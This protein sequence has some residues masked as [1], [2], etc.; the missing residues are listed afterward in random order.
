M[1]RDPRHPRYNVLFLPPRLLT[2]TVHLLLPGVPLRYF[3]RPLTKEIFPFP[4]AR[5]TTVAGRFPAPSVLVNVVVT[6]LTLP[7]L[8]R[9]I[10][11]K[12]NVP[13]PLPTGHGEYIRLIGLL[14]RS[15]P[16]LMTI[17]RPLSPWN[18]VNTVVL[19]IRFLRTLLLLSSAHIWQLLLESPVDNVTLIVVE[20]FRFKELSDTLIFGTRPTLGRFRKH[21]LRRCSAPKLLIGKQLCSVSVE[22]SFGVARFPDSIKWLSLGPP[23]LPGLT[24]NLLKHKQAKTLVVESDL[25]GRLVPVVR[26][27]AITF[28]WILPVPSRSLRPPTPAF[29]HVRILVFENRSW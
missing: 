18:L 2:V 9:L 17:M 8:V 28:P 6:R 13:N 4:I 7:L 26:M 3:I 25:F 10:I 27:V 12:P 1:G 20:T 14:T 11:R 29:L 24:P 23:G 15:L 21:E 5:V 16:P 22:H 19:Y